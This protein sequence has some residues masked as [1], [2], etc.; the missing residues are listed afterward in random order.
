MEKITPPSSGLVSQ[1]RSGKALALLVGNILTCLMMVSVA[2]AVVFVGERLVQDWHGRYLI[3]MAL[4]LSIEAIYSRKRVQDFESRER[5]IFRV[6]EWIAFAVAIKILLYLIHDPAQFLIDLPLWQASF[7]E[8]FITGEYLL[9]LLVAVLVWWSSTAFSA[10]IG[11]LFEREL[12]TDWD[13]LGKLQNALREMRNKIS[14]RIFFLGTLVVGLAVIARVETAIPLINIDPASKSVLPVINALAYFSFGLVLLTQ[15]QFALL[16]TRWFTQHMTVSPNLAKN[17]MKYGM[18]F[19]LVLALVVFFLPTNYS[20]GFLDTIKYAIGYLFQAVAFLML[21]I[22]LPITFCLSLF[23]FSTQKT[24]ETPPPQIG[25]LPAAT[26]SSP[27]EWWEFVRSLAFWIFFIG[28]ILFALR[29]YITQNSTLWIMLKNFP[30]FRRFSEFWQK[31]RTW[32]KGANRQISG[33]ITE[34][35]NKLRAQRINLKVPPIQKLFNLARMSTREKIIFYYLNLVEKSREQGFGRDPSQTPINYEQV[36]IQKLPDVE[37]ELHG[38]TASFMEARYS[39][40]SID[41]V[42]ATQAGNLWDR[43]KK[44]LQNWRKPD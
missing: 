23:S 44:A 1:Y 32:F 33:M 18:T 6:S 5:I 30:F 36:L 19:F 41:E 17:W 22:T 20:I 12:E 34:G 31:L 7:I 37:P 11:D 29:Y 40:H 10:E 35:L 13:D 25:A 16:R 26:P 38:L 14:S 8:T 24:S 2:L 15:T 21:L 28:V 42:S 27:V 9:A 43:I 3:W 4:F 39:Q